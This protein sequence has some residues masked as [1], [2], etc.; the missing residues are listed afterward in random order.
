VTSPVAA[1]VLATERGDRAALAQLLTIVESGGAR[2]RA[3]LAALAPAASESAAVV[4]ITGAPGVGKSTLTSGVVAHLRRGGEPVAVIAVDPSSEFSGGAMLGDRV[5]MQDHDTDGGVFVRSMATRGELGGLSRAAP[6]AVRVLGAA[7]Y[8]WVIIETVGV[9]Q[10]EV[11]VA[12][13]AD[14]TVVV[15]TPGWGDAVQASKAGLLEIGDI[16]VVNKADRTGAEQTSRD[17]QEMLGGGSPRA[18]VPP[19]VHTVATE[20]AG[21]AEL[22][23]AV[24]EHRRYLDRSGELAERRRRRVQHELRAIVV[25]QLARRADELCRGATFD[26]VLTRIAAGTLDPY[27]AASELL[28]EGSPARVDREG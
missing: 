5:R 2:A 17:L 7:G 14:T 24:V 12:Q 26:R 10:V 28:G 8:P 20:R 1:L 18:W 9:G 13:T 27:T 4:G 25:E 21:I 22:C 6:H 15:V 11:A 23:D 16:F 3:A 19:V